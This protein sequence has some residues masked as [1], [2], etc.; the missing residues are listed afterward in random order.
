M[1]DIEQRFPAKIMLNSIGTLSFKTDISVY[2]SGHEDSEILWLYPL[3]R[4]AVPQSDLREN[5]D[6]LNRWFGIAYGRGRKFRLRDPYDYQSTALMS[7]PIS[8]TDQLIGT[9]DGSTLTYQLLKTYS[10]AGE[11]FQRVINKPVSGTVVVSIGD[12]S[13]ANG[14]SVDTTTGIITFDT[15][16]TGSITNITQAAQ[17]VVSSTGHT[18]VVGDTVQIS[19]V[20]GM[21]EINGVRATVQSKTAGTYTLDIDST[22]FTA[23]AS[24]GVHHTLPQSSEQ[25]KAGY[26]YDLRVR[27]DQDEA[28]T[29]MVAGDFQKIDS[30]TLV[31]V[32]L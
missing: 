6:L 29:I 3:K 27:F 2:G 12:V 16:K 17:A 14:W 7:D 28:D 5:I 26:E 21:T 4:F 25:I 8:D 22:L 20:V 11:S 18:L 31:E 9:G 10:E 1:V 23:Y 19:G 30:L 15:D 13:E 24:G 32:R